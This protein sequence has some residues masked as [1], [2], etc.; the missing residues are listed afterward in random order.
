M[1][2]LSRSVS[3][4]WCSDTSSSRT[5]R[6]N[7]SFSYS[8]DFNGAFRPNVEIIF[9]WRLSTWLYVRPPGVQVSA[10]ER[11]SVCLQLLHRCVRINNW[12]LWSDWVSLS[13]CIRTRT[14]RFSGVNIFHQTCKLLCWDVFQWL[15]RQS[16]FLA[17][18][19]PRQ[20]SESLSSGGWSSSSP[21]W[22]F[23]TSGHQQR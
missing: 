14:D 21:T 13:H 4:M 12:S 22:L 8:G 9:A 10:A 23:W 17:H 15:T 11:P 6:A 5:G 20:R 1:G 19:P 18:V 16:D 3:V 7:I 2:Y